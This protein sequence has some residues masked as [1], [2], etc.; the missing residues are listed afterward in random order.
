MPPRSIAESLVESLREVEV[1]ERPVLIARAREAR[2]VLPEALAE[3]GA[4]VDV[5]PLYETVREEADPALVEAARAADYVT[6]TS[7]STVRNFAEAMDG[8]IG[9]ARVVSIGPVTSDAARELGLEVA[10]EAERHDPDGLLAALLADAE[11]RPRP[12]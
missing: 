12:E 5:V 7:A 11:A 1:A 3:R 4:D 8:D 10:V 2:D 6:F 9:G